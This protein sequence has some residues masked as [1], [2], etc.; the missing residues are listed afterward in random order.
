MALDTATSMDTDLPPSPTSYANHSTAW[1]PSES[2]TPITTNPSRKRSRDET[3]FEAAE[4][5]N[6][7]FPVSSLVNPPEPIQEEPIY[8]EGM[9][10]LNPSTGHALSAE[11]QTGTWYE[12]KAAE[13]EELA[14]QAAATAA[15]E[16]PKM[17]V[18]RKS[19]RL[20]HSSLRVALD[21]PNGNPSAPASPPKSTPNTEIDE[22]TIALGIGW[23][24]LS[25][26]D[27]DI[28][29]AARGWARYLDVHY[30]SQIHGAEI[31]LKNKTLDAYVV[32]CQEGFFLFQE[33]LLRGQLVGRTWENTLAN[34]R[35]QPMQFE[36]TEILQAERTPGPES[37]LMK[38][39]I[40]SLQ[41]LQNVNGRFANE[42]AA[43]SVR[44]TTSGM[45]LD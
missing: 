1:T 39:Q 37:D 27:P 28:V 31:L 24:K 10:L 45:D 3:A 35:S 44:A 18:G 30:S 26:D 13:E 15:A 4:A 34:L 42:S 36:G 29:A 21:M 43:N 2:M 11:T 17:P 32:G 38:S 6:S 12:E 23:T 8:G 9:T 20:S 40:N 41:D 25:S 7:Y 16:R 22:A 14:K 33:D 19:A 5:E